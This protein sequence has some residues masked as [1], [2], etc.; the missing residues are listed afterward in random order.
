MDSAGIGQFIPLI[1]I[2]V[3]Q[4]S[5]LQDTFQGLQS[6]NTFYLRNIVVSQA[7]SGEGI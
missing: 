7:H 4:P 3:T 1:L 6:F 2:F 5:S